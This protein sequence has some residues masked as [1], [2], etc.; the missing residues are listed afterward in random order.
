MLLQV[1]LLGNSPCNQGSWESHANSGGAAKN[2]LTAQLQAMGLQ[3][4]RSRKSEDK[5]TIKETHKEVGGSA[6]SHGEFWEV[7]EN[8][9][10]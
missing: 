1:P 3:R 4:W 9:T 10:P 7:R 8:N 2:L 6:E 5:K